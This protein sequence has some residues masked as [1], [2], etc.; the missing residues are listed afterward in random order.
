MLAELWAVRNGIFQAVSLGITHLEV[1]L[2]SKVDD[3]FIYWA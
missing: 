1:K 3:D 2:D